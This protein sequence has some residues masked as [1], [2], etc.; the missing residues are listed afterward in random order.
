MFASIVTIALTAALLGAM[1][2][3]VDAGCGCEKAPPLLAPVRPHAAYEGLEVSLFHRDFVPGVSYRVVF[4][5]GTTRH[6]ASVE[7]TAVV[8][9]DLADG[10]RKPQVVARIPAGMPVGPTAIT[11]LAGGR[12]VVL[13]V[14]DGSFTVV[15][16]PFVVP[17]EAGK[18]Q[19][20]RV[21]AAVSRDGMVYMS[22]DL[23]RVTD[24]KT[25]EM[26]AKGY[27]LR[28]EGEDVFFY[29]AQGFLMQLLDGGIP[30]LFA[31]A[32]PGDALDSD[33]LRYSRHEFNSFFLQHEERQVHAVDSGDPNWHGD[34]TRHIDHNHLIVA[35]AGLHGGR[36]PVPG[37]TP[38]FKLELRTSTLFA[39]GIVGDVGVTMTGRSVID[40]YDSVK[41]EINQAGRVRSNGT[42]E[43]RDSAK[44]YGDATADGFIVRDRAKV[45]GVMTAAEP[46]DLLP[47]YLPGTV[48]HLGTIDLR[49]REEMAIRG[50]GSFEVGDLIL[51]DRGRLLIDNAAGP[52]TLYV[53][54]LVEIHESGAIVTT[55]PDP[56]QFAMYVLTG[57][58]DLAGDAN[59]YGVVYAP[60]ASINVRGRGNF[61][62]ALVGRNVYLTESAAVHYDVRL[63]KKENQGNPWLT[64]SSGT[65]TQNDEQSG[66]DT[67]ATKGKGKANGRKR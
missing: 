62:G 50:P 17:D 1:P 61:F 26:Q 5:S 12:D 37:A 34:G 41:A 21:R 55:N 32:A 25:I 18:F 44:I 57:P 13:S 15:P 9:R 54:G 8:R 48:E 22:L 16:L 33:I 29:N 58:V 7:A 45:T 51:H 2:Q 38:E 49:S 30:G 36:S 56:E 24:P 23:S 40:G 11:V 47:I 60:E 14:D 4:D 6:R 19:L 10:E 59:L 31:I 20:Q 52:V 42:V 3:A 63:R 28:F 35:I 46:M 43:L 27:P 64:T 39:D 66:G 65:D 67:T 53:T